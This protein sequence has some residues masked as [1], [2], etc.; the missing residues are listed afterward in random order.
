MPNLKN[1]LGIDASNIRHGGGITHLSQLLKHTGNF[2]TH[3]KIILWASEKTL[4][5]ISDKPWLI[6]RSHRLLNGNLFHRTFWQLFFL[7]KSLVSD[8]C[9]VL[10]APGGINYSGF[11]PV[12]TFHQNLLPFVTLEI[13][14]FRSL[15]KISRFYILRLLQSFSFKRSN[16]IIFLSNFSK[17]ILEKK[18]PS[19]PENKVIYHG[20]ESRFFQSPKTQKHVDS[21]NFENPYKILYVSSIDFYKHQWNVVEAV[22]ILRNE[23][24]PV[25]LDLYGFPN[26]SP[27]RKL[28]KTINNLDK[29]NN[30]IFYNKE[31]DFNFMHE[32]YKKFDMSVFASSCETFGQIVLES[33]A[34][35]L[36][37]ACSNKSSMR[38]IIQD[39]CVYFNPLSPEDISDAIRSLLLSNEKRKVLAERAF[40]R[41]KKFN[42]TDTSLETFNFI[43]KIE[44][45]L[46]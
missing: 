33:M 36:P 13:L 19:L 22:H 25:T 11:R 29:E 32:L 2:L 27:M 35:G 40:I 39:S 45:E 24:F 14:R 46:N 18:I 9:S 5:Q 26:K 3:D 12:I 37:I 21:Y 20:I 4:K 30:F 6:K 15:K 34:S 38:E 42:W 23:G 28:L 43:K 44:S 31:I 10:F 17:K 41:S 16:G 7:K 8:S 1:N